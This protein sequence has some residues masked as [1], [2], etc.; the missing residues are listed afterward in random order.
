MPK[1]FSASAFKAQMR[2]VERKMKSEVRQEQRKFES[3][4]NNEFKRAVQKADNEMN[5]QIRAIN[6]KLRQQQQKNKRDYDRYVSNI[7]QA[8]VYARSV[9]TVHAQYEIVN[10]LYQQR[11]LSPQE[12]CILELIDREQSDC[13]ETANALESDE[14]VFTSN[15]DLQIGKR[16]ASVSE[17]LYNR[18]QGAVFALNPHN[19][20]AA[21]HFCTSSR[22]LFTDFIEGKAPDEAVFRNN[23]KAATTEKKHRPEE[24]K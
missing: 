6:S 24:K 15:E 23:P 12:K 1:K 19:P 3:K 11:D 5:R 14:F 2:Q 22:E 17:D 8:N 9:Q 16:L 18:W 13:L 10:E 7:R 20:E 21:R 4:L